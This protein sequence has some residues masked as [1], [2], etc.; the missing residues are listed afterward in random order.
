MPVLESCTYQFIAVVQMRLQQRQQ[1]QQHRSGTVVGQGRAC[2]RYIRGR[3]SRGAE[4]S[5]SSR[6]T[7]RASISARTSTKLEKA[8][9]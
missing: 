5:C 2:R 8:G 4:Y 1:Q 3:C 9:Q 7:I 6:G